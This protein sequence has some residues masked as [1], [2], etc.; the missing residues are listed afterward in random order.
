MRPVPPDAPTASISQTN[1]RSAEPAKKENTGRPQPA[2]QGK[3]PA[4]KKNLPPPQ[5]SDAPQPSHTAPVT[6]GSRKRTH[7]VP[8]ALAKETLHDAHGPLSRQQLITYSNTPITSKDVKSIPAKWATDL[9]SDS[10]LREWGEE[11]ARANQ[12]VFEKK[13]L[14]AYAKAVIDGIFPDDEDEEW[15]L[16][17]KLEEFCLAVDEQ[18]LEQC[19]G[20][21]MS[22]DEL[23]QLRWRV[24]SGFIFGRILPTYLHPMAL[25]ANP[26]SASCKQMND[27][28]MTEG[29]TKVNQFVEGVI[30]FNDRKKEII[31]QIG[32][33]EFLDN[34]HP[35]HIVSFFHDAAQFL[36]SGVTN[37]RFLIFTILCLY[38]HAPKDM[39]SYHSKRIQ[40]AVQFIF[41]N[42]HELD[43]LTQQGRDYFMEQLELSAIADRNATLKMDKLKQSLLIAQRMMPPLGEASEDDASQ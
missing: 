34:G 7:S 13:G 38:E 35:E 31:A 17:E 39:A 36:N 26:K 12:K 24:L 22:V 6:T 37:K 41:K 29:D 5:K 25:R 19:Q 14:Q 1:Q 15:N 28:L 23:D 11:L 4:N 43:T 9:I 21:G 16:P 18:L 27:A 20:K 30:A 32:K 10:G 40:A 3:A 8:A 2:M 42:R 33:Q